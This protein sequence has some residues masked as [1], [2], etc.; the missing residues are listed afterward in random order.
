MPEFAYTAR[1]LNGRKIT[2]SLSAANQNEALAALDKKALFPLKVA[3]E[4][5]AALRFGG[6][7]KAQL[8]ATTY[9]QLADLLRSGVPLL[10]SLEVLRKQSSNARLVEVLQDV[11]AQVEEGRT[12]GEAMARH[13]KVFNEMAVNMVRAGGEGAFLEEALDRVAEFTEHQ[14]DMK[15]RTIGALIYPVVLAVVG[16]IVVGVLLVFFVPKFETLFDQ[17]REKGTLPLLTDWLLAFSAFVQSWWLGI[18]GA[19]IVAAVFLRMRLQT[20]EGRLWSD[21]IK[22]RMPMAG[23]IYLSMAVARFCRVLGTMLRNGVPILRSLDISSK[24]TGNRVLASAIEQASENISAG[25]SLASPLAACG[26]FPPAV[27]EM[28]SVAEE[29]NTLDDVL[30]RIAIGLETRTWR[31]LDLMV[32]L[33]EPIMLLVLAVIVLLL[34]IALMLPIIQMSTAV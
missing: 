23:D 30:V 17:M 7:I 4:K 1:D 18:I 24:A 3:A 20:E 15:S 12:L 34:A 21:R 31:R 8:V 27:V 26:Y 10:R 6:R 33:L 14:Q 22:L 5:S 16:T 25:E 29:A 11:H 2:G 13:P 32:R 28:I 9:G 19:L